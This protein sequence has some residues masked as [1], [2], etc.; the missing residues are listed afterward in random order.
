MNLRSLARLVFRQGQSGS[1][2]QHALLSSLALAWVIEARDPYTGGHLWRVSRFATLPGQQAGLSESETW[3]VSLG[4]FLHDLG[5]IA[6]PDNILRK[7]DRLTKEEYS[8]I[9]THSE[10]G[11][12]LLA[13]HPIGSLAMDAV[14]SHHERPDGKSYPHGLTAGEIPQASAIVGIGDAFDAMTR[15]RPYRQGIPIE[16]ALSI[17]QE[18][19]GTQFDARFGR[20]FLKL[21]ESHDLRHIVGHSDEGIPL[22][23][24]LA[25]GP[26]IVIRHD[27]KLASVIFCPACGEGYAFKGGSNAPAPLGKSDKAAAL[28]SIPDKE[29][30]ARVVGTPWSAI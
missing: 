13:K 27:T 5:K 3:T 29:L 15:T 7:T 2:A 10:I 4:A 19:L 22:Q 30:I 21:G 20:D 16:R 26:T 11:K 28:R 12:A 14:Y 24:C 18:N 25:C 1:S 9:K 6:V 17:I 8:V 23:H